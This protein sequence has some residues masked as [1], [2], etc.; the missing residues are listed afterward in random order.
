VGRDP[1]YPALC[2]EVEESN[3]LG[4]EACDLAAEIFALTPSSAAGVLATVRIAISRADPP[5]DET[6]YF[7]EIA[8]AALKDVERMLEA[9]TRSADA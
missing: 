2:R 5:S 7:E 8:L 3:R 1:S 4:G 6:S 9:T